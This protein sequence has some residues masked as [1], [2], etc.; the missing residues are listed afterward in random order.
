VIFVPEWPKGEFVSIFASFY[1]WTKSLVCND[2]PQGFYYSEMLQSQKIFSSLLAV[3]TIEPSRPSNHLSLFHPSRR[4]AIR[5]RL[6]TDQASSVQMTCLSVRTLHCVEKVLSSLYLSGRFN[7]TS[8]RLSVLDQFEISFQLPRKGRS[9]N[10]PDDVVCRPDACLLKARIAIQI[11]PSGRLTAVVRTSVMKEGNYRFDFNHPDDCLPWFERAHC[12][13]GNCMLKNS[14]PEA[15]PPWS[16]RAK[17]Y[18]EITCNGCP[19][20]WT[21]CHPVW[22]RVLNRKD[23]LTNFSKNLVVQLSVRTAHVHRSDSAQ[24]LTLI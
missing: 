17:P 22:T 14:R 12:K 9:I 8:G 24:V 15:H 18:K 2:A 3:R 11:S 23:F 6:Q 20:V 19:T 7:S 5:S 10:R 4:C 16:G 21:M 1:V 13:Y